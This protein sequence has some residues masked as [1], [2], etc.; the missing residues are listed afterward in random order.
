M[1]QHEAFRILNVG[2]DS[3][4]AAL[5]EAYLDLLEVWDP[6]RFD[7]DQRLLTKAKLALQEINQ[8]YALLQGDADVAS[9]RSSTTSHDASNAP[10]PAVAEEPLQ[11]PSE[12]DDEP[13][14]AE[15][16]TATPLI[17]LVFIGIAAGLAVVA[18]GTTLMFP[19]PPA[20][21][22]SASR[23]ASSPTPAAETPLFIAAAGTSGAVAAGEAPAASQTMTTSGAATDAVDSG[24]PT[25]GIE[26]VSPRRTGGG[27][28]VIYNRERRDAVV[29]L[30]KA[31]VFERAVYIRAGE[32]VELTNVAAGTYR[33]V[34]MLGRDWATD[35][36]DRNSSFRELAKPAR[37]SE[38]LDEGGT[39]YTRLT[40]ALRTPV[41]SMRSVRAARPFR[42]P[43]H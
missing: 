43:A 33:V 42:L 1:T 38:R 12:V 22:A 27:S 37:F 17:Q 25:S 23:V 10:T 9:A 41:K 31:R 6:Y 19:T 11:E 3:S 21:P 26:M 18:L 30:T 8:A 4:P 15:E 36:F 40:V 16:S 5:K 39:E 32:E 20:D 2:D 13:E 7:S 24:R 35:R 28:L 34:M 29:A 14:P